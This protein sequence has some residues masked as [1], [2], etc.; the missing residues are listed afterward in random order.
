MLFLSNFKAVGTLAF[1]QIEAGY[2]EEQAWGFEKVPEKV[3]VYKTD[4]CS[5]EK[6]EALL[7]LLRI[8]FPQIKFNFD[9]ADCDKILRAQGAGINNAAIIRLMNSQQFFCEPLP[10]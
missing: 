6:A 1:S 3:E 8:A 10:D 4:V 7:R 2:Q 9:L 5:K